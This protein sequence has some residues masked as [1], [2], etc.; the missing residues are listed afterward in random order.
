MLPGN[1]HSRE[2]KGK[3]QK[4]KPGT[5]SDIEVVSTNSGFATQYGLCFSLNF[6][7]LNPY[8]VVMPL[9]LMIYYNI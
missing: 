7:V 6:N 2:A 9:I 5:G 4:T 1:L 8:R 3:D